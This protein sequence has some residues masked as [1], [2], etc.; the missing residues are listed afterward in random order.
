M[1]YFR[2]VVIMFSIQ[3]ILIIVLFSITLNQERQ[4]NKLNS[5]I[6]QISIVVAIQNRNIN[7][8]SDKLDR[9]TDEVGYLGR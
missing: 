2:T 9:L 3:L 8:M 7:E 5:N 1:K 4:I 6:E